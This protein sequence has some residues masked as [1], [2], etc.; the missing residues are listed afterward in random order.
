M[1]GQETLEDY[2]S[3]GIF[4]EEEK[5]AEPNPTQ[6]NRARIGD[7]YECLW[8]CEWELNPFYK[9]G[10]AYPTK[11]LTPYGEQFPFV[12]TSPQ[13]PKDL[14]CLE[15][16]FSFYKNPRNAGMRKKRDKKIAKCSE[17]GFDTL[18]P[19]HI[20]TAVNF[21]ASHFSDFTFWSDITETDIIETGPF[22]GSL[23]PNLDCLMLL[24]SITKK[25]A[26][27]IGNFI[28]DTSF[29]GPV[30]EK[31]NSVLRASNPLST[32]V[33]I[34]AFAKLLQF[35]TNIP[36]LTTSE[37]FDV[38]PGS[39]MTP[40]LSNLFA[41][42]QSPTCDKF[43]PDVFSNI[44]C[45]CVGTCD[46]RTDPENEEVPTS[47]LH[48]FDSDLSSTI[49]QYDTEGYLTTT[50]TTEPGLMGCQKAC[51]QFPSCKFFTNSF[52]KSVANVEG[53]WSTTK[54]VCRLWKSCD[55]FQIPENSTR[56]VNQLDTISIHWSGPKDC[57][58]QYTSCPLL[59]EDSDFYKVSILILS[60]S[61]E[62][63]W[64]YQ[65]L[66]KGLIYTF[67]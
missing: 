50:I 31:G 1:H 3:C 4:G 19:T 45:R 36:P 41:S 13:L 43:L 18:V 30:T 15:D 29:G 52:E 32:A 21:T 48:S 7:D 2:D 59:P 53:T 40:D 11:I 22:I 9:S 39:E 61:W 28:P 66:S 33:E 55:S 38:P 6:Q 23:N 42:G 47:L 14:E 37:H 27:R 34:C 20:E 65:A 35:L 17:Q 49:N 56:S 51:Q 12:H 62:I 58:E 46:P 10:D 60:N 67:Y 63:S 16:C 26:D 5:T 8:D 54:H 64:E 24:E 25:T 44:S 57:G